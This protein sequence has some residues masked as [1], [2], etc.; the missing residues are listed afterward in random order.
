MRYVAISF[1]I[2]SSQEPVIYVN[3]KRE[4]PS[5]VLQQAVYLAKDVI[6]HVGKDQAD[7]NNTKEFPRPDLLPIWQEDCTRSE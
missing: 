5:D 7:L 4:T 6:V 1:N 2:F 3:M